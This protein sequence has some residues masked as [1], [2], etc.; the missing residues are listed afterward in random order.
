MADGS[1]FRIQAPA[2]T[3]RTASQRHLDNCSCDRRV[4]RKVLKIQVLA[5]RFIAMQESG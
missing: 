3:P 5:R 2:E 1:A 4:G